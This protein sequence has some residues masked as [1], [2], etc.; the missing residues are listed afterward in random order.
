MR[1]PGHRP[2]QILLRIPGYPLNLSAP[3]QVFSAIAVRRGRR[4]RKS[5]G[6]RSAACLAAREHR[7]LLDR[8]RREE[9]GRGFQGWKVARAHREEAP[10]Y[11]AGDRSP[12]TEDGL[13]QRRRPHHARRICF[14]GVTRASTKVRPSA[15]ASSD[16][17][18]GYLECIGAIRRFTLPQR[19][20]MPARRGRGRPSTQSW[21]TLR[22]GAR[23]PCPRWP[24]RPA[25]SEWTDLSQ[26]WPCQPEHGAAS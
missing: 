24:L 12:A 1:G 8:G 2:S 13:A 7:A 18:N 11:V 16:V 9:D 25:A 10:A 26:C 20:R 22:V 21:R 19:V 3:A 4:T 15:V 5:C 14:S 17:P 23:T 6:S